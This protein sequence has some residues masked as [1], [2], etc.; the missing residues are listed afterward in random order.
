MSAGV[1]RVA[2]FEDLRVG[3]AVSYV[4]GGMVRAGEVS[5][6]SS[7]QATIQEFRGHEFFLTREA[8][9]PNTVTILR[10]V[11]APPVTVRRDDYDAL[12]AGYNAGCS[13]L[14]AAAQVLIDHADT[15]TTP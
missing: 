6:V 2:R 8:H 13:Q 5:E 7:G 15:G 3:Q 12:V 4:S 11:S 9:R 1:P 10:D 14:L